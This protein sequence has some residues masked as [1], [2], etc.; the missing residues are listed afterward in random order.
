M[1]PKFELGRIVV[2][3]DAAHVLAFAGQD[4]AFFLDKHASGDWGEASVPSNEQGLQERS[5]VMSNYRTLRG[6]S[7]LVVTFFAKGE[8]VMFCPPNTVVKHVIGFY[9][10]ERDGPTTWQKSG[11]GPELRPPS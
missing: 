10:A 2:K 8:T 5:M 9:D 11:D 7:L 4:A 1:Q 3:D 6:L